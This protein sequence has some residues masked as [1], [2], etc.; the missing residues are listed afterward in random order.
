[1]PGIV[2]RVTPAEMLNDAMRQR[3]ALIEHDPRD[4]KWAEWHIHPETYAEIMNYEGE[5][6]ANPVRF[7]APTIERPM[8]PGG[9]ERLTGYKVRVTTSVE[10]GRIHLSAETDLDATIRHARERG[11]TVNIMPPVTLDWAAI[12]RVPEPT[13]KALAKHWAGKLR[14]RARK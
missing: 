6:R 1:M 12:P 3:Y 11:D 4:E 13:V 2:A 10:P 14:K 9:D 7:Y 8:T 5:R